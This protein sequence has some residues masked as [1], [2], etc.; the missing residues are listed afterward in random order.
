MES[1]VSVR[2]GEW[3][4]SHGFFGS[5]TCFVLTEF[6]SVVFVFVWGEPCSFFLCKFAG[7]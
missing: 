1:N 6:L 4:V 7:L 5:W 2:F 3:R